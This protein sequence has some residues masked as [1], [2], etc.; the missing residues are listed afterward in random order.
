MTNPDEP[1]FVIEPLE[2]L[3]HYGS[4]YDEGG[5]SADDHTLR[6]IIY[7]VNQKGRSQGV[8]VKDFFL[9]STTTENRA[10]KKTLNSCLNND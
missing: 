9:E 4:L 1:Y 3:I 5:L 7:A 6:A 10:G 8:I 2:T